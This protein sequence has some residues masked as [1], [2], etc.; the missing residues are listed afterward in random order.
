MCNSYYAYVLRTK[1]VCTAVPPVDY[2]CCTYGHVNINIHSCCST[3]VRS[4]TKV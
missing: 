3:A 4:T 1:Y 2:C